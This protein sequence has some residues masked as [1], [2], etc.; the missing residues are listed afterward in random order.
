M[1][2]ED[3][4]NE[5]QNAELCKAHSE[6]LEDLKGEVELNSLVLLDGGET[7]GEVRQTLA[8]LV[9]ACSNDGMSISELAS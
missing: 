6:N 9:N 2:D 4:A 7:R 3:A 8:S 5:K 1:N